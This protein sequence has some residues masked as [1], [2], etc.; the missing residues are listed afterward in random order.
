M[1]ENLEP[2][3]LLEKRIGNLFPCLFVVDIKF[4]LGVID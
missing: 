1:Y 2:W 3:I 4:L